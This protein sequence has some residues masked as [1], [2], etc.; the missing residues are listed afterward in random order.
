MTGRFGLR[1]AAAFEALKGAAVLVAGSGLL[2]LV[3]RDAQAVAERF[4]MHLHLNPAARYPRIF[5]EL[6]TRSTG[7]HL[8]LLA[9]G[10]LAYSLVRFIEAFLLRQLQLSSPAA[11]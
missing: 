2:L 11:S 5:I 6:A 7:P 10:A 4:V 9:A 8:R 3:H 1:T